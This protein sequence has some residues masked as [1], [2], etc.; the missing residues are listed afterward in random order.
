MNHLHGIL[1]AS[2]GKA[3]YSNLVD[4]YKSFNHSVIKNINFNWLKESIEQ[5]DFVLR[6]PEI[7]LQK[8]C[9]TPYSNDIL[10]SW[11][12]LYRSNLQFILDSY[13][14][15]KYI[16]THEDAKEWLDKHNNS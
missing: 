10:R 4:Y 9:S 14:C 12:V 11:L 1:Y 2:L 7:D 15:G 6:R 16:L 5:I 3:H 8:Y 13:N